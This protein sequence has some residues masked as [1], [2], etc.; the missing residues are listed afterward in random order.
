MEISQFC[1]WA[2][3]LGGMC[4]GGGQSWLW[5]LVPMSHLLPRQ[6]RSGCFL[7]CLHRFLIPLAFTVPS[8]EMIAA[9]RC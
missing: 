4:Y 9:F 6:R 3:A 8:P 5:Q 1:L 2:S 7:E